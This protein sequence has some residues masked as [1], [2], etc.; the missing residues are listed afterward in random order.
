MATKKVGVK[1]YGIKWDTDGEKVKGLPK[2]VRF[3]I[4]ELR[5]WFKVNPG[6]DLGEEEGMVL[7]DE[8]SDRY[9]FCHDG[10]KWEWYGV[11]FTKVEKLR[12]AIR[13]QVAK[14]CAEAVAKG[15]SDKVGRTYWDKLTTMLNE[16][17]E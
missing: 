14:M 8:L 10:F 7:A 6:D 17:G 11:K 16:L 12:N 4:D 5:K 2:V 1:V 15:D 9:G 13:L 3:T